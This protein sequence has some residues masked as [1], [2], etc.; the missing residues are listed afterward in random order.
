MYVCMSTQGKITIITIS[1]TPATYTLFIIGQLHS[2]YDKSTLTGRVS[3]FIYSADV[4][5]NL[6]SLKPDAP[7]N[8][9]IDLYIYVNKSLIYLMRPLPLKMALQ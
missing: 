5:E 6:N 7:L 3:Y 8:S 4:G 1:K 9:G 2:N